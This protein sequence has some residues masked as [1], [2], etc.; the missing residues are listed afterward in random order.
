MFPQVTQLEE[1]L[2]VRHSVFVVGG[3]GTGKS[4]V[5]MCLQ[6]TNCRSTVD[7]PTCKMQNHFYRH[8]V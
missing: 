2:A 5:K 8:F 6:Y 4:Q 1:L 7:V 3:A